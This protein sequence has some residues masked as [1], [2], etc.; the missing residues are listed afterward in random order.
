[1]KTITIN[2]PDM[3]SVHCQARV[4]NAVRAIEGVQISHQEPGKI[5]VSVDTDVLESE[6]VEVIEKAGY[7]VTAGNNDNSAV[8]KTGCCG[9]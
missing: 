3:Q 2:V 4:S 1:M 7:K 8:S 6:V 9:N 5:S